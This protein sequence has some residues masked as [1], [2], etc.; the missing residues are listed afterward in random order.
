VDIVPRVVISGD[1]Q[2]S[3]KGSGLMEGLLAMLLSERMG[4]QLNLMPNTPPKPE[5]EAMR[6]QMWRSLAA[7][8]PSATDGPA[9]DV[10]VPPVVT[11]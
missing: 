9:S 1:G 6:D 7:A 3:G 11:G 5:V 4:T 2:E 8:I 10:S